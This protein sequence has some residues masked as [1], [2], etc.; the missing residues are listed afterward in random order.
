MKS[1]N[2]L[3]LV[4]P[5]ALI[6]AAAACV[7]AL[8]VFVGNVRREKERDQAASLCHAAEEAIRHHGGGA[9][10][11]LSQAA[12]D[13]GVAYSQEF[14]TFSLDYDKDWNPLPHACGESYYRLCAA[15]GFIDPS[16][17]IPFRAGADLSNP[18]DP[19]MQRASLAMITGRGN[20]EQMFEILYTTEIEWQDLV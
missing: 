10:N 17:T 3:P 14:A 20:V 16:G 8:T 4:K 18:D 12:Q 13:L 15:G 9:R 7:Y 1:K 5:L 2:S 6:L 11:A 19:S